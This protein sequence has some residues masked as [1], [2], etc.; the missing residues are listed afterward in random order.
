M[1]MLNYLRGLSL[2]TRLFAAVLILSSMVGVASFVGNTSVS[3]IGEEF[4]KMI[5]Y[6]TPRIVAL[7]Q[8]KNA[9]AEI[10]ANIHEY[11]RV[12][13][14]A[15]ADVGQAADVKYGLLA[16]IEALQ[17]AYIEY[18]LHVSTEAGE[19][20]KEGA[21]DAD[22]ARLKGSIDEVVRG[23]SKLASARE[24]QHVPA[25]TINAMQNG[26]QGSL[27]SLEEVVNKDIDQELYTLNREDAVADA[28]R[29]TVIRNSITLQL[30]CLLLAAF[31]GALLVRM[32]VV[33]L[34]RLRRGVEEISQGNLDK[35]IQISSKDEM[36]E[37]AA[38]FNAMSHELKESY[39]ALEAEKSG[40]EHQVTLR[41]KELAEE[42]FRFIASINNLQVGYM[43]TDKIDRVIYSN[44]RLWE[45]LE[46]AKDTD[47][48]KI[49]SR[50]DE[51]LK[52]YD[53]I[54]ECRTKLKRIDLKEVQYDTKVLRVFLSPVISE[55]KSSA[56]LGVVMLVSDITEE[57]VLQ[58]SKDEFF[59][60]ASHELRTPLTAIRGNASMIQSYYTDEL[61]NE[62]LN[63]MVTDIHDSSTRLIEIVNDFLDA[64]R[65]EQGKMEF[66]KE[67][68]NIMEIVDGVAYEMKAVMKERGL[69]FKSSQSTKS[70]PLV[71]A[72]KDRMK[73]VI[74]N[75]AGNALKF[76]EQGGI[77]I[78]ASTTAR[79]MKISITDTG[80]GI[81]ADKQA[82]LFHKF[83]QAGNSLFTRDATRGTG[84]G[85][86]I[87]RLLVDK[88]GGKL[89]LEKSEEGVGT[90][91]SFTIPIAPA[92][93]K[94]SHPPKS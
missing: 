32:I 80:R 55:K 41:T 3:H 19:A 72:D 25:A 15:L 59:S 12:H 79:A 57:K 44:P 78:S 88:M 77:T 63:Q 28:L 10:E 60:I 93:A 31:L 26:L 83:Q 6:N 67:P 24:Q 62:D 42:K 84:M 36:G 1:K 87:S 16:Q 85:L 20:D 43:M 29:P 47:P 27:E 56:V 75:L 81:P 8:L 66:K 34:S 33:P 70:L 13:D 4:D 61:K 7:L 86:Y 9:A 68:I 71:M 64:S 76:T 89:W 46:I 40:V 51:S 58:R 73:Q 35:K 92:S 38:A 17:N 94:S 82:L 50:L 69:Y 49:I 22:H 52:L 23:A 37:L 14:T 48:E 91:F 21:T 39:K 90:T 5:H 11:S 65:L 45:I 2:R 53:Y 54:K 30:G 18:G 74:Y